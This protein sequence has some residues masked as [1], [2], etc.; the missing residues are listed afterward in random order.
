V[1]DEL[2]WL[3]DLLEDYRVRLRTVVNRIFPSLTEADH[4]VQKN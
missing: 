1:T 4:A 3:A 2:Q